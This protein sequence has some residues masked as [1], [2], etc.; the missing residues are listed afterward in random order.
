MVSREQVSAIR[1]RLKS[2]FPEFN[3]KVKKLRKNIVLVIIESGPLDLENILIG[4]YT[5]TQYF[6]SNITDDEKTK[7]IL[8][9]IYK[10]VIEDQE[11]IHNETYNGFNFYESIRIGEYPNKYKQIK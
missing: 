7:K 9:D 5:L 6:I 2:K 10:T 3:F 1:K 11:A 8:S 4:K